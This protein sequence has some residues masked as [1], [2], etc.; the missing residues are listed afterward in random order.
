[1]RDYGLYVGLTASYPHRR[2]DT[3]GPIYRP[4]KI[5]SLSQGKLS[6]I[7]CASS[8]PRGAWLDFAPV[9]LKDLWRANSE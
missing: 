6:H 8:V 2:L 1:M 7:G 4:A 9:L 5:N 3:L